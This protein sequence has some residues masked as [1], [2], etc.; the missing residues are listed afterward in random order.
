MSR[1]CVVFF[2]LVSLT[3]CVSSAPFKFSVISLGEDISDIEILEKGVTGEDCPSGLSGYGSYSKSTAIAIRKVEG[4]NA[5]INVE[6]SR[7]ERPI[8]KLCVK[9][10]GDAVRL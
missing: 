2:L 7:A 3:A 1:L 10:T 4:A 9:V 8:G 5:L 6:F